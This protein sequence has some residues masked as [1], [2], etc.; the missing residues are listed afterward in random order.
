MKEQEIKLIIK[1]IKK[2]KINHFEKIIKKY[3]KNLYSYIYSL[4]REQYLA[5]DLLQETLIKIYKNLDKYDSNKNFSAWIITIAR[6]TV[7]DHLKKKKII[8][9]NLLDEKDSDVKEE[10]HNPSQLLE[11]KEKTEIIDR[12][13]NNLPENYRD[14]IILKY[15][16]ELKYQEIADVLNIEVSKVKWKLYE[17]R[18]LLIREMDNLEEEEGYQWNVK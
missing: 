12:V 4:V 9:L 15:F 2:G 8:T 5:E 13:V 3:D 17:A 6:N 18:K 1:K 10:K 14:I 16:D 11:E 7:Y